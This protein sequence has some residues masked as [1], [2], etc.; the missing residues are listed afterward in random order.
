M[1][2]ERKVWKCNLGHLLNIREK[3]DRILHFA[4]PHEKS[5]LKRNLQSIDNQIYDEFKKHLDE[6]KT[7]PEKGC[8]DNKC[9]RCAMCPYK[10]PLNKGI[11]N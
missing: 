6:A 9:V 5:V 7:N 4:S 3:L 10:D 1:K 2:S 11:E 8:P